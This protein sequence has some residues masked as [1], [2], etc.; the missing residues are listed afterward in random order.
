MKSLFIFQLLLA[1]LVCVGGCGRSDP[2]IAN[3]QPE[4]VVEPP[5]DLT[6]YEGIQV[7]IPDSFEGEFI[8]PG[9]EVGLEIGQL[10]PEISGTDFD[11][12]PFNIADYR[13]KVVVL[14]FWGDWCVSCNGIFPQMRQ[15]AKNN[16]DKDFAIVGVNNDDE[17]DL[18]RQAAEEKKLIWRSFYDGH[19][20]PIAELYDI[21]FYP[22]MLVIDKQGVIRQKS[23]SNLEAVVA[24]LLADNSN[25]PTNCP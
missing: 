20:G 13:G 17:L 24:E 2:G 7:K 10:A 19:L 9:L 11:G 16:L 12:T 4:S 8:E 21:Q 6:Q 23:S 14:F 25:Q 3:P 1:G 22:S 15:L 18:A 5:E